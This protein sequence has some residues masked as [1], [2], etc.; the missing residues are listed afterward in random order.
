VKFNGTTDPSAVVNNSGDISAHVPTGATS[1]RITVTT[2]SGTG[3][4]TTNF[5][6][7]TSSG[8]PTITGFTPTQGYPGTKVTISGANFTGATSVRLGSRLA[9]FSVNQAGTQI[10]ATVPT[11]SFL[12]SYRWTV[13]TP[14]GSATST[15][16]FRY[17]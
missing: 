14:A 8:R 17:L 11:E 6:V 12:G 15:G 4:S 5:M 1:G 16:L 2:S 9:S 10:T 3:T 13:T 7:S